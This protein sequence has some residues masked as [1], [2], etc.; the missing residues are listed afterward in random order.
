MINYLRIKNQPKAS[1]QL[2]RINKVDSALCSL[3]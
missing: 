2:H 1:Q 3:K